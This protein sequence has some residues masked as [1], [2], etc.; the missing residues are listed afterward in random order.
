MCRAEG[1][2]CAVVYYGHYPV[3]GRER[4]RVVQVAENVYQVAPDVY[5]VRLA[6]P[7]ALSSVNCYL[8]RGDAGWTILDTGL[9]WPEGAAGWHAAFA[10]LNVRP[11]AIQQIVLTH[12]HPDHYGM[13]GWLQQWGQ[14]AGT[15]YTPPVRIA[16]REAE[17]ARMVWDLPADQPEPMTAFFLAWG[18]PEDLTLEMS[19]GV[20]HLRRMTLPHPTLTHLEPGTTLHFGNR[21][22]LAI[23][24]PGHS[25]G[26]LAFYDAEDRLLLC[27]DHLLMKITPHIG[28]WPESEPN[29]LGRYLLSLRRLAQ[30]DVRLALTGHGAF[31]SDWHARLTELEQ[32][33]AVRL[34]HML[35]AAG[36]GATA[37][38]ICTRV[39][40]F[41]RLTPH[42]IRFAIAETISHLELLV[43]REQLQRDSSGLTP[44]Y[45]TA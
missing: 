28:T 10:A 24:T 35:K 45:V 14:S 29:P 2:R 37:F 42:E 11:A 22:F 33:H 4:E 15:G 6:L 26:H 44:R 32:H 34:A 5:C 38:E 36:S 12:F 18:V 16:P 3:A 19:R 1:Q 30:L 43:H 20:A 40:D 17:L 27:G 7:F 41:S 25:D 23:H 31:I 21:E 13:A 9:H 8:L 39:F